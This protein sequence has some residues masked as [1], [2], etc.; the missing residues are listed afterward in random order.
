MK[1][2]FIILLFFVLAFCD[3]GTYANTIQNELSEKVIRLHVIAN[4]DSEAS[5]SVKLKVRDAILLYMEEKSYSN[6]ETAYNS[7]K[8]SLKDI[9][10]IANTVLAANGFNLTTTAELGKFAFPEKHY[11]NLSFPSGIYTALRINIGESKGQNWWCVMYP[12]LCFDN[13]IVSTKEAEKNLE[14][15][16]SAE[17]F[18]LIS[19]EY[20]FKF[21]I[22]DWFNKCL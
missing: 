17:T 14:S 10:Q 15:S 22:V 9:E 3:A 18:A 20:E 8:T 4:D 19:D 1:K 6:F 13:T 12:N 5:Q 16:L 7:V 21:K 11:N 2:F